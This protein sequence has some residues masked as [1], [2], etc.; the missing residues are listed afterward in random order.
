MQAGDVS[1]DSAILAESVTVTDTVV[2][3]SGPTTQITATDCKRTI[4]A[5][6][7]ASTLAL[8]RLKSEAAQSGFNAIHSVTIE[9]TGAA[10]LL[11]NCWSQI[12]ASGIAYNR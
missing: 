10:A 2:E 4:E 7:P 11:S 8:D 9:S 6:A 5:S 1:F 3:T 12:R